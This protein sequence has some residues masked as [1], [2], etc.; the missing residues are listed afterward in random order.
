LGHGPR[1][2]PYKCGLGISAPLHQAHD[3]QQTEACATV[4][5]LASIVVW[6]TVLL[7]ASVAVDAGQ[8]DL[9]AEQQSW[10][11]AHP[12]LVV[13][14]P[15]DQPPA[16][17]IDVDGRVRGVFVELLEL[18]SRRLGI[19]ARIE[20]D[21]W[22]NLLARAERREIDVLGLTFP[23]AAHR[24][25]FDFTDRVPNT[26][27]YVYARS[28][29]TT[30]PTDLASL[31]GRRVGYVAA[32]RIVEELMA[33]RDDLSLVPLPTHEALVNALLAGRIDSIVASISLEYWR[34]Q[35][36]QTGFR[37]TGMIPEMGG[38]LVF[39]VRK[40]WPELTAILNA[41]LATVAIAE[42]QAI[43]R[44]WLGADLLKLATPNEL[45]LS[46]EEREWLVAH[47]TVRTAIDP[48]WAP[49]L[50]RDRK[51]VPQGIAVA[52]LERLEEGLGIDFEPV[53]TE[54]WSSA[55]QRFLEG[56]LDLL[57]AVAITPQREQGMLLTE[58]Y[59]TFPAAIFSAAEVAYLGGLAALR[60]STVM[61]VRGDAVEEWLQAQEPEIRLRAA[62]DTRDALRRLASGEAFA[63][64]GNLVTTSY[65]IGRS[66]LNQIRVAGETPFLYRLSM[67]V[68]HDEPV[69]AS[70]L[71]KGL[72][73]IPQY[74]RDQIYH[75][76]I[77]IRYA[78]E[79]ELGPLLRV[80]GITAVL[81]AI[82]GLW[83]LSLTR[84][85]ARRRRAEAAMREAKEVAERAD[86]AKGAFLANI[87]HELRTPLNVVLGFAS[88]LRGSA[89]S[90]RERS[91]LEAIQSAGRSL[92]QLIDDLLDLTRIEAGHM[93]PRP[94]AT[95]LRALFDDLRTMFTLRV[96]EKGLRLQFAVADETPR[97]L[98]L[99]AARVRQVL[100]NLIGNAIKF[101]EAG[102]INVTASIEPAGPNRSRLRLAVTDT[103]PGIT[104]EHHATI[105]ETF[106]QVAYNGPADGAGLGLA[107]SRRLAIMMGGNISVRSEPG[108]GA[109]FALELPD[110][111]SLPS[112][113]AGPASGASPPEQDASLAPARVLIADDRAENRDL[114]AQFLSDQPV[115]ILQ[116]N[117]G[118]TAVVMARDERPDLILM[119][120]AMPGIDGLEAAR[121]IKADSAT[122]G[123]PILAVTAAAV[124]E[125][126]AALQQ[127]FERVL[128]RPFGRAELLAALARW[129]PRDGLL[130]PR[131]GERGRGRRTSRP[132]S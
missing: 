75:D 118:E 61:V 24:A 20:L 26:V 41:G 5:R 35:R 129:L 52:Y 62:S 102:E 30:P 6:A 115:E 73:A 15:K 105:F 117:D 103:G 113:D 10:L 124:R 88:L 1:S 99:D 85:I 71:Q 60:G 96:A 81:L 131:P 109:T 93:Q 3:W 66:G 104:A 110:V 54:S 74:E 49:V 9:S 37:V 51:G 47:P 36:T 55:R 108:R 87:S 14:F 125:S 84:E 23:L 18:L 67:A 86:R 130:R 13:G 126:D 122:A 16:A 79:T 100:V 46:D 127:V 83:N 7:F 111:A 72:S 43:I 119:D 95:D 28:D 63:F 53:E 80:V 22:P 58:P 121:R 90:T 11:A 69:L 106:S 64:V 114:L 101:T 38:D 39:A 92:A 33:G 48:A 19:T 40:D 97:S 2:G 57:P 77:S 132:R 128:H 78:Q 89:L 34:Q 123:I 25:H 56:R 50:F 76:W 112:S 42:R 116:A 27:Y 17:V 120:L 45:Q 98:L 32:T 65:Y 59:V 68:P 82:I 4:K 29:E 94:I 70:L 21:T 44:R 31:A 91:W 12:D 8:V 107:I